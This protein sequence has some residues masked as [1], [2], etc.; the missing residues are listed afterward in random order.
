MYSEVRDCSR[1]VHVPP[2]SAFAVV[3]HVDIARLTVS[4]WL[5]DMQ[6]MLMS[7]RKEHGVMMSS[8]V[9]VKMSRMVLCEVRV[10]G[11]SC[12]SILTALEKFYFNL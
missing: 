6:T 12:L 11:R 3:D 9:I 5:T 2:L 4:G 7:K 10:I 1:A 8:R